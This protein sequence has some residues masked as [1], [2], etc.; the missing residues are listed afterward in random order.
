MLLHLLLLLLLSF[1][2]LALLHLLLLRALLLGLLR[3]AFHRSAAK[4][5]G[6]LG[7]RALLTEWLSAELG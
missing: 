6:F 3:E 1:L 2:V 5:A 7:H 4:L